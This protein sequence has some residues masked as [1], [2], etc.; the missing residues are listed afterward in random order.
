MTDEPYNGGAG[1]GTDDLAQI[2]AVLRE[3]D[4]DDL[5]P[6][7]PP[8]AIWSGIEQAVAQPA[9]VVVLDRRSRNRPWL[10]AAAAVVVLAI[11]GAL[12]TLTV[13]GDDE[14]VV[15][16]A[17]LQHDPATFDP[18]GADSTAT[19][20]LIEGGG[21]FELELTEADLPTLADDDLELWLIE[22]DQAG[23]PVDV[24]PVAVIESS[25]PGIYEVPDGLD[26]GS[27]YVVDISIE[28]RD[29]DAAHS[30]RSILR[31]PLDPT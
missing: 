6:R 29:G 3:L 28:P 7:P 18:L 13:G 24:Q 15:S 5:R 19:A 17:V 16:T 26:P 25:R 30:G 14:E 9:P 2:Q 27:H 23:N 8:P 22:P 1:K 4:E 20:R 21:H 12:V 11:A 31:G 10:L